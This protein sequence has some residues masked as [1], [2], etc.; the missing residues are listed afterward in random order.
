MVLRLT[1]VCMLATT[2]L[3]SMQV[4]VYDTI[5]PFLPSSGGKVQDSVTFLEPI[6]VTVNRS[7]DSEG[8]ALN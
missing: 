1:V 8:A 7:G 3:L 6:L 4:T 5:I 2:P